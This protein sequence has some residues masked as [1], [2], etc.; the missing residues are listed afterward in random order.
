MTEQSS[1]QRRH[2]MVVKGNHLEKFRISQL[3]R[4]KAGFGCLSMNAFS[5]RN[6]SFC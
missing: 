5:L 1:S 6:R 2:S 3:V 4:C